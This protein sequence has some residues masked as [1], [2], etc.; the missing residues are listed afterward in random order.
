MSF[1]RRVFGGKSDQPQRPI[2]QMT[3]A[4]VFELLRTNGN[5][6][7]SSKD[8]IAAFRRLTDL[9]LFEHGISD[10]ERNAALEVATALHTDIQAALAND[11]P[12]L[13]AFEEAADLHLNNARY[14]GYGSLH[15]MM[16]V[17]GVGSSEVIRF[18]ARPE[19]E[20]LLPTYLE[21]MEPEVISQIRAVLLS[22]LAQARAVEGEDALSTL[23]RLAAINDGAMTML[24]SGPE[25]SAVRLAA[26]EPEPALSVLREMG[27]QLD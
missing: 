6:G 7:G 27:V 14:S 8:M 21:M 19:H 17:Q 5:A 24:L 16:E 4:E 13:A 26:D 2:D 25:L 10:A 20:Q 1:F 9:A 15:W 23:A 22:T 18:I 12:A 11:P 3:I